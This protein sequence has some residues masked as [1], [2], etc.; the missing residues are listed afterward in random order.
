MYGMDFA[1]RQRFGA[2][3]MSPASFGAPSAAIMLSNETDG[4][5]ID[6]TD[7]SMQI[8]DTTTPA[9]A[10]AGDPNSKLTYT[11]PSTWWKRTRGGVWAANSTITTEYDETETVLGSGIWEQRTW[12]ALNNRD[13]AQATWT[14]TN[15]TAARTATGPDNVSSSAT[16][17]TATSANATILQSITSASNARVTSALIRRRTGSGTIEMT[18]D[19]GATWTNITSG[20]TSAGYVRKSI[21]AQTIANPV[22]GFRLATS[23]DEID[24]DLF[25]HEVGSFI[26]PPVTVTSAT[27]TRAADNI[28][29]A[30]SA[31]PFAPTLGTWMSSTDGIKALNPATNENMVV[32]SSTPGL[33]YL[34]F[35]WTTDISCA[36]GSLSPYGTLSG[37]KRITDPIKMAMAF[38][39][40]DDS[41]IVGNGVV[42]NSD[43]SGTA[44]SAPTAIVLG[45]RSQTTSYVNGYIKKILYV[46]RRMTNPELVTVTT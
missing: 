11:S 29:I 5:A 3:G 33:E 19:N 8:K 4:L 34:R 20:V 10:F 43:T 35:S 22:V 18:Q 7:L 41:V 32:G 37:G 24:F 31:F 38:S 16:T 28:S 39:S 12:L 17:F 42:L 2:A 13:G 26:T 6:F 27:V 45:S 36:N 1:R 23:G 15:G 40:P 30:T 25:G 46:P 14:K 21:A 44:A 9:N